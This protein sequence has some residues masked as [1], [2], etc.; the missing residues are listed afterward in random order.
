M[1]EFPEYYTIDNI[2]LSA[3][4]TFLLKEFEN[5]TVLIKVVRESE[6]TEED[7]KQWK[8]KNENNT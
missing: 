4:N 1:S 8:E 7:I 5:E 3:L 2:G 6:V